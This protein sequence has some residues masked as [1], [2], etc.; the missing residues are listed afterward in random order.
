MKCR[1]YGRT[2]TDEK[3]KVIGY[4]PE[5]AKKSMLDHP[6]QL[7]LFGE[8]VHVSNLRSLKGLIDDDL[9]EELTCLLEKGDAVDEIQD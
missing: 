7:T 5:C 4:G 3:S 9:Y 8:S 2:L 6:D 1:R